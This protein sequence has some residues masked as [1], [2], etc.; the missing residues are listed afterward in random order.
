VNHL[1]D[2]YS[3]AHPDEDFAETVAV[4]LTPNSRWEEKYR[5]WPALK[6]LRYVEHLAKRI[7]SRPPLVTVQQTPWSASRMRSTLA[8][9][10]D[11]KRQYLGDDFPGFYD[12]ALQRIFSQRSAD[13]AVKASH[14]LR[15]A[16]RH[17]VNSV[18]LWT[19]QRKFDT[20]KLVRK[21]AMR[22]DALGLYLQ[23]SESDTIYDVTAFVTAAMA[24]IQ[25]FEGVTENP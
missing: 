19:A 11:R 7:G 16:R 13:N 5:G 10:Y 15:A 3:Q 2:N 1:E 9:Y 4:W 18:S 14:F 8:A 24:R 22:C 23:K 17:I 6:K 21:L 20:D 12:P 25:P